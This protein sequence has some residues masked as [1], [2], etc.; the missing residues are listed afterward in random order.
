MFVLAAHWM[1]RGGATG[2]RVFIPAWLIA[3]LVNGAYGMVSAGIPLI[4]EIGALVPIFGIP[5][6]VAWL[7]ARRAGA[8]VGG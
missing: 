4:N 1:G 2:A 6:G 5:A 8:G 3:A 7:V